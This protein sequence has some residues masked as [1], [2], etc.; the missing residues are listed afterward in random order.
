M[1]Y[2]LRNINFVFGNENDTLVVSA[3]PGGFIVEPYG[4]SIPEEFIEL[5]DVIR[6]EMFE[7]E[8]K[9]A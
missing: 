6:E 9:G 5:L 8:I 2:K 3:Y 1:K 7:D 4:A